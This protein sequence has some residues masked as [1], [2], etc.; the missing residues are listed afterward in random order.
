[1]GMEMGNGGWMVD[2]WENQTQRG[3]K[4]ECEKGEVKQSLLG[5][6]R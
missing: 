3:R 1:M 5:A 2:G 6:L 4:R